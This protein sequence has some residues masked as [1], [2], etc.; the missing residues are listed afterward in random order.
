MAETKKQET[1]QQETQQKA[2]K[3]DH[4]AMFKNGKTIKVAPSVVSS[5]EKIGWVRVGE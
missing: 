1:Q 3:P 2:E 5:H 4:V